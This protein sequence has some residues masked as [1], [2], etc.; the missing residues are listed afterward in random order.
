MV[1]TGVLW[2]RGIKA[3]NRAHVYFVHLYVP[4]P[5]MTPGTQ[6]QLHICDL[7]QVSAS[8]PGAITTPTMHQSNSV[9]NLK[10]G[11]AISQHVG[12]RDPDDYKS[13]MTI[14]LGT[15]FYHPK[16]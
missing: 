5:N 6:Q 4:S 1:S 8:C 2:L 13:H 15:F 14:I 7:Q 11:H 3:Q 12:E 9:V 16:C 10:S